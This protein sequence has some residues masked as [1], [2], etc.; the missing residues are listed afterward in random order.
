MFLAVIGDGVGPGH[1]L[2]VNLPQRPAT[3]SILTSA[4]HLLMLRRRLM[5]R[6]RIG[7]TGRRHWRW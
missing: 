1:A 2:L 7:A 4:M 3:A 6:R 5:P